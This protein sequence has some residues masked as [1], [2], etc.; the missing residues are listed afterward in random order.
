MVV[1]WPQMTL[2]P[3]VMNLIM[4][5]NIY[6]HC[7]HMLVYILHTVTAF[8]AENCKISTLT[9]MLCGMLLVMWAWR[10]YLEAAMEATIF[11]WLV[12][13]TSHS[14]WPAV[15]ALLGSWPCMGC[16]WL[17]AMYIVWGSFN[18]L[19]LS[20]CKLG[21]TLPHTPGMSCRLNPCVVFWGACTLV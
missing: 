3:G 20:S 19:A 4:H 7:I 2:C 11:L 17:E 5:A 9:R 16:S 6:Y 10:Y 13:Y 18:P 8:T 14:W 15:I 12:V 1:R 21:S